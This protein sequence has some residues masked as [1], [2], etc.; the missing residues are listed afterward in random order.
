[1]H[2]CFAVRALL[3]LAQLAIV[4]AGLPLGQALACDVRLEGNPSAAW[5]AAARGLPDRAGGDCAHLVLRVERDGAHLIFVTQDGRRA[6]RLLAGPEELAASL[7]ALSEAGPGELAPSA[8]ATASPRAQPAAVEPPPARELDVLGTLLGG[9]RVGQHTLVSPIVSGS[10]LLRI[11][12][13]ELGAIAAWETGYYNGS[14]A[15]RSGRQNRAETTSL[16]FARRQPLKALTL[17]AGMRLGM[18]IRLHVGSSFPVLDA[19]GFVFVAPRFQGRVGPFVGFSFPRT[20]L[21]RLRFEAAAD[22]AF[23]RPSY[24]L[25]LSPWPFWAFA[26]SVGMELGRP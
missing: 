19:P 6:D 12:R 22:L 8:D 4:L 3:P 20:A 16:T 7:A 23:P 10:L 26:L 24:S 13:W 1:M 18:A 25:P 11:R 17:L 21:A 14:T 15:N 2:L 5:R 9:A